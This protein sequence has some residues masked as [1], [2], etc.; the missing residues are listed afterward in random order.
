[1]TGYR[2]CDFVISK[3]GK[4]DRPCHNQARFTIDGQHVC[5][6]HRRYLTRR[7]RINSTQSRR[8]S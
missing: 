6:V 5:G 4:D 2:R 1:M 8:T 3:P 7:E